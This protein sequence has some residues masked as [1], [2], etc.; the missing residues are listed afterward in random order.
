MTTNPESEAGK[1]RR[2]EHDPDGVT[3]E[4]S[5]PFRWVEDSDVVVYLIADD[6]AET[7]TKWLINVD[8]TLVANADPI[9]DT[10]GKIIA[11]TAPTGKKLLIWAETRRSQE[12]KYEEGGDFP[13]ESHEFA[14]D[15]NALV[16]QEDAR[17]LGRA[18]RAPDTDIDQL[19]DIPPRVARANQALVFDGAGQPAAGGISEK[20]QLL[21]SEYGEG[22]VLVANANAGRSYLS[23]ASAADIT[24]LNSK[25]D[26]AVTVG[27]IRARI[28]EAD[29]TPTFIP[30]D[31]R[32]IGNASSPAD[33]A[34]DGLRAL[35]DLAKAVPNT[36]NS[37]SESFDAGDTVILADLRGRAIIGTGQGA[38]LTLRNLGDILGS[39]GNDTVDGATGTGGSVASTAADSNMQPSW[40]GPWEVYSGALPTLEELNGGQL[41]ILW[42][43]GGWAPDIAFKR[44]DALRNPAA[45]PAKS[46]VCLQDHTS[47][48]ADEPGLGA[49]WETFWAVMNEDGL[50]GTPGGVGTWRGAWLSTETYVA[51]ENVENDGSSYVATATSTNKEP[52]VAPDWQSFWDLQ[53]AKGDTG[54]PGVG[55][56]TKAEY[57]TITPAIPGVVDAAVVLSDGLGLKE[58]ED[59]AVKNAGQT[60]SAPQ[61]GA[62]ATP[63]FAA[64]L[65]L[66]FADA[67]NFIVSVV[68]SDFVLNNP[69]SPRIGAS[70]SIR[71]T[72][73]GAGGHSITSFG[74]AWKSAEGLDVSLAPGASQVTTIHYIV[75]SSSFIEFTV[76][77]NL[78]APA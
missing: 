78:G 46:Y 68:T 9:D 18:L 72:Q 23:A 15:K 41:G 17:D 1:L 64:P 26:A 13:S 52:G 67:Q 7:P 44:N 33:V 55:D 57:A 59:V 39:E 22:L 47:A 35:F 28:D 11:T 4:F 34:N 40:A 49:N 20:G 63:D 27:S 61:A 24:S 36:G 60:Y 14:L 74:S 50:Q 54:A 62:V 37:G 42:N 56:M 29:L 48:A 69:T 43:A 6:A 53:A 70:G 3:T 10:G 76:S 19:N 12:V 21:T 30:L 66:N 31:G 8:Y 58:F 75:W 71:L 25:I 77:R 32:T 38:G 51:N 65:I 16:D 2:I 5:V 73:D 45:P